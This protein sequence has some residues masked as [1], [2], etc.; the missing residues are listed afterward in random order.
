MTREPGHDGMKGR[1]P[2]MGDGDEYS[3]GLIVC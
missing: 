1:S 3:R 2:Q